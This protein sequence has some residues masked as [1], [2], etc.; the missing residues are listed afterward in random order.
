MQTIKIFPPTFELCL[1]QAILLQNVYNISV[2]T[3]LAISLER[4]WA[5]CY[6][7]SHRRNNSSGVSKTIVF[8]SWTI[9]ILA[10][11]WSVFDHVPK[12][13]YTGKCRSK[14]V[15]KRDVKF[16]H[17]TFL[18]G[19]TIFLIVLHGIIFWKIRQ[20]LKVSENIIKRVI[21]KNILRN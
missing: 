12:E 19:S 6:P 20:T 4:F 8:F 21:S 1:A 17:R 16:V 13:L 2:A 5:V 11:M 10:G 3:L 7:M 9:P 15:V 18:A 14:Y